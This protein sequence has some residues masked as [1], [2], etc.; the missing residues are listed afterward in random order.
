MFNYFNNAHGFSIQKSLK[1]L[2]TLYNFN[3]VGAIL[4]LTLVV[5]GI[6][7]FIKFYGKPED[8]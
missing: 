5:V 2:H 6:Y 8:L 7:A 1:V 4:F 3:P